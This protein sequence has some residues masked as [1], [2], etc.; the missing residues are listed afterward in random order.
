[1][2][3][4]SGLTSAAQFF[5]AITFLFIGLLNFTSALSYDG[6]ENN[7][8]ADNWAIPLAFLL[9]FIFGLG[10]LVESLVEQLLLSKGRNIALSAF[11]SFFMVFMFLVGVPLFTPFDFSRFAVSVSGYILM[12][13]FYLRF[14]MM[15]PEVLAKLRK[16]N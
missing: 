15:R 11:F 2:K 4:I 8:L 3:N 13:G 9:A 16:R 12:S 5:V 1:M 14:S 7:F 10:W 6:L